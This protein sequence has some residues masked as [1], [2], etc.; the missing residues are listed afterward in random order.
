MKLM[1]KILDVSAYLQSL[2]HLQT[3]ILTSLSLIS[4]STV[5]YNKNPAI[6]LHGYMRIRMS[7]DVMG[8][9]AATLLASFLSTHSHR[10]T[11]E[12]SAQKHISMACPKHK[13][14]LYLM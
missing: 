14:L 3:W 5:T 8:Y 1:K 12:N 13:G 2:K 4:A 11:I 9:C 6:L 7:Q 10:Q